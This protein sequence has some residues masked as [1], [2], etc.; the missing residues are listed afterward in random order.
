MPDTAVT[1][2][3]RISQKCHHDWIEAFLV[4]HREVRSE[5]QHRQVRSAEQNQGVST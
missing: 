2:A 1:I 3:D 5:N 4:S